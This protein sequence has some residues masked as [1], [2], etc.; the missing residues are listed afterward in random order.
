MQSGQ[1]VTVVAGTAV[2]G[3]IVVV[4]GPGAAVVVVPGTAV[5]VVG[6]GAAVVVVPGTAVVVVADDVVVGGHVPSPE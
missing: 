3:A 2:V 4:V 1:T 6:P 5:V